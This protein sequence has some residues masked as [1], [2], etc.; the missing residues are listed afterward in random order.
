MNKVE[1]ETWI[2]MTVI[3]KGYKIKLIRFIKSD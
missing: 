1:K 2:K 3:S